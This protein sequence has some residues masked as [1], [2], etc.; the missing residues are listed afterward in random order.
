MDVIVHPGFPVFF[1][2]YL[3][4]ILCD[5]W[6]GGPSNSCWYTRSTSELEWSHNCALARDFLAKPRVWGK[7]YSLRPYLYHLT[8]HDTL[9]C[10]HIRGHV[11]LQRLYCNIYIYMYISIHIIHARRIVVTTATTII[12]NNNN[13][14]L[15][16]YFHSL[17]TRNNSN[18][19]SANR[20]FHY[21]SL[22]LI[23]FNYVSLCFIE[24][25][26]KRTCNNYF[27]KRRGNNSSYSRNQWF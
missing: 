6:W 15:Y 12:N 13:N 17:K 11:I 1:P 22:C 10:V 26:K 8:V 9:M 21:V 23:M 18:S 16:I 27:M 2:K 14:K 4:A 3:I 25:F 19:I 7:S 24:D 5:Q 20:W